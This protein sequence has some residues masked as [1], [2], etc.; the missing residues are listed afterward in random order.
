MV[1]L[2][3]DDLI[4]GNPANSAISP[5]LFAEF[6]KRV[7]NKPAR[8]S[9]LAWRAANSEHAR[10]IKPGLMPDFPWSLS[11]DGRAEALRRQGFAPAAGQPLC[12]VRQRREEV[13]QD[14]MWWCFGDA[15]WCVLLDTLTSNGLK[16]SGVIGHGQRV[17]I[18]DLLLSQLM[19]DLKTDEATTVDGHTKWRALAAGWP[20]AN[21]PVV[22]TDQ[23]AVV[24]SL[25]RP[26]A[27]LQGAF[28][29]WYSDAYPTGH[30]VGKKQDELAYEAARSLGRK[31]SART[32]RRAL[33][34]FQP[35]TMTAR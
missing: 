29:K 24:P 34:D 13:L 21:M 4:S 23:F 6:P 17:E 8:L 26:A 3:Y 15:A 9:L 28:V 25:P 10:W 35:R 5:N 19:V 30:P 16:V 11:D 2:N 22:R 20:V 33:H 31:V 32:V 7:E 14:A 1:A 12:K 18:D 27:S